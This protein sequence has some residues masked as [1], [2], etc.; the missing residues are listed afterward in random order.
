MNAIEGNV[1][2]KNS[3]DCYIRVKKLGCRIRSKNL[4]IVETGDEM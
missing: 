4:I 1:I 2:V 3:S